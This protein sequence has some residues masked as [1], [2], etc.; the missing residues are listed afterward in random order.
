MS[1][2]RAEH[3]S[4]RRVSSQGTLMRSTVPEATV[5]PPT[6]LS[7]RQRKKKGWKDEAW[8]QRQQ[9]RKGR[10]AAKAK[11]KQKAAKEPSPKSWEGPWKGDDGYGDPDDPPPRGPPP[12]GCAA[13]ARENVT[14]PNNTDDGHNGTG[15]R[16]MPTCL[17]CRQKIPPPQW[18]ECNRCGLKLCTW[19]RGCYEAH[20]RRAGACQDAG[21]R[22][23][24]PRGINPRGQHPEEIDHL[25]CFVEEDEDGHD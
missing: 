21:A 15:N 14:G 24:D 13:E 11:Q 3:P 9:G 6:G 10:A 18:L 16:S 1:S 5:K 17:E 2:T 23:I 4:R 12:G 25:V 19:P 22:V 20:A 7:N 8:H